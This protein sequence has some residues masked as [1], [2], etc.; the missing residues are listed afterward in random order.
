MVS[1]TNLQRQQ[2][3]HTTNSCPRYNYFREDELHLF[4]HGDYASQVWNITV[5]HVHKWFAKATSWLHLFQLL[6]ESKQEDGM[7]LLS[8]VIICLWCLWKS[9][10]KMVFSRKQVPKTK[11]VS[12][13]LVFLEQYIIFPNRRYPSRCLPPKVG[14]LMLN[15]YASYS[16]QGAGYGLMLQNHEGKVFKSGV[17]LLSQAGHAEVMTI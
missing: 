13:S 12:Y 17:G 1:G 11:V 9:R 7:L 3:R 8:K 16:T 10:N 6:S 15:T 2:I 5:L 14:F 4:I